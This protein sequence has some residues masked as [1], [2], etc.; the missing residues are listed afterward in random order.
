MYRLPVFS[1]AF[2]IFFL[3]GAIEAVAVITIW[4]LKL[5]GIDAVDT[6]APP[7]FWHTYEM[8]FGFCRAVI[9]GFLFTAGQHWSGRFLLG[10]RSAFALFV[11]WLVGRFAFYMPVKFAA[12]IFTADAAAGLFAIYRLW[13]LAL[14]K[15]NRPVF[16][17]V[18][19]MSIAQLFAISALYWA[20]MQD[21]FL[22]TIRFA[23]LVVI[24]LVAVIAGRILPFFASV[25][26]SGTKPR[27]VPQLEK[28]VWPATVLSFIAFAATPLGEIASRIAAV[29]FFLYGLLHGARWLL[30]RPQASIPIPILAILYLGYLWLIAGFILVA[31]AL[32][33]LLPS[34]PAWHMFGI[35]G[36]GVFIFGMM[37]RVALG[38]TGRPIK[39]M[40]A[41]SAAYLTLNIAL[42][43]RVTLPL[44]GFADRAYLIAGL[45]W[46]VS[47][48]LYLWK[49]TPVLLQPRIDGRPG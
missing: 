10:G 40:T 48:V 41:M 25:V 46:I 38:H 11:L 3:A 27:I 18:S 47:F 1:T 39:A 15:H 20:D 26:V 13:P 8:V 29:I 33:G 30:W 37:T 43:V 4:V 2:R 9:F 45:L 12:I 23:L 44:A 7:V 21:Y 5:L 24:M 28:L 14:Q 42:V 49:Y 22:H 17:M 35:G 36:A 6:H 16:Y 19:A 31:L 32:W 34:S